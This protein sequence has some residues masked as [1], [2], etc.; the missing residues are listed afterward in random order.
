MNGSSSLTYYHSHRSEQDIFTVFKLIY[1]LQGISLKDAGLSLL[2]SNT[3]GGSVR[4]LHDHVV[5]MT[6]SLL[7]KFRVHQQWNS[8]PI[9][10]ISSNTLSDFK[11]KLH[12]H[13]IKCDET[14]FE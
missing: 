8:L 5:N 6:T 10:I 12:K 13:L 11:R 4:L 7:F 1:C 9:D 2:K 3:R 14:F